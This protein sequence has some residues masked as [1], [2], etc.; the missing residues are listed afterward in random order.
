MEKPTVFKHEQ[1]IKFSNLIEDNIGS[2]DLKKEMEKLKQ[3]DEDQKNM[4]KIALKITP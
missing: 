1:I 3:L 4:R 2:F